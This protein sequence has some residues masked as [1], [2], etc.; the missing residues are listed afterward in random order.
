[1]SFQLSAVSFQ[2]GKCRFLAPASPGL[3]MT[4]LK[5]ESQPIFYFLFS[6]FHVNFL[7][8]MRIGMRGLQ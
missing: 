4:R 5:Q 2:Q 3:G 1:M 7:E 6:I 8:L